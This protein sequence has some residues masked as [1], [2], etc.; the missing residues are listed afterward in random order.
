MHT[1]FQSPLSLYQLVDLLEEPH[2]GIDPEFDAAREE[3]EYEFAA[4]RLSFSTHSSQGF[5]L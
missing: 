2:A 5:S 1:Q 3:L 4:L